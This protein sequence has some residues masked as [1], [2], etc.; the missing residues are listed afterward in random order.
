[1]GACY[2]FSPD[3]GD[4]DFVAECKRLL[5]GVAITDESIAKLATLAP[6]A[7]WSDEERWLRAQVCN[8]VYWQRGVNLHFNASRIWETRAPRKPR[9]SREAARQAREAARQAH[10][11]A[12]TAKLAALWGG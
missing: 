6:T 5:R 2:S 12:T 10:A 7:E 3:T 8:K 11:E 1:M 9:L 4:N